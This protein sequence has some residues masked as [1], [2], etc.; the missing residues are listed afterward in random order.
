M[1]GAVYEELD[2]FGSF[3][4]LL[5]GNFEGLP[6]FLVMKEVV[7]EWVVGKLGDRRHG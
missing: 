7:D 2:V 5:L 1:F 3:L 4:E 6:E